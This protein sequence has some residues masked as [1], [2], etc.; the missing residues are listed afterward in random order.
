MISVGLAVALVFVLM[1]VDAPA[2]PRRLAKE[3]LAVLLAQGA[4]GFVQ[5]FTHVPELLVG[6][7]MLGAAL[8]WIAVLRLHLSLRV[9]P[10]VGAL[11]RPADIEALVATT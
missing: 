8:C 7:H 4:L 6:I 10:G 2:A 3:F 11:D 5:Y 1:A 9:R